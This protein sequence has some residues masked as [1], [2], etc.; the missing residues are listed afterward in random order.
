MKT[1]II[2]TIRGLIDQADSKLISAE[3][4][5]N[6]IETGTFDKKEQ[7]QADKQVALA[8]HLLTSAMGLILILK[9]N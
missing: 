5:N 9:E 3:Y 7:L 4:I 2:K 1:E 6:Q 8:E